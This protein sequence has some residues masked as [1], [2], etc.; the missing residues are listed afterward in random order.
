MAYSL[1]QLQIAKRL[2][3]AVNHRLQRAQA[4]PF[5]AKLRL[6]LALNATLITT[7]ALV[8]HLVSGSTWRQSLFTV[9][10]V[11]R[12]VFFARARFLWRRRRRSPRTCETTHTRT[13]Q[14]PQKRCCTAHPA[15]R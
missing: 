9:Y 8:Y 11:R 5:G 4:S 7:G 13:P 10:G 2:R 12:F 15:S 6:F 3:Q 14:T 1:Q